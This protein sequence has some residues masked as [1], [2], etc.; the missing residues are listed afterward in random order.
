ML[1]FRRWPCTYKL[2]EQMIKINS[3]C[4]LDSQPR[5]QPHLAAAAHLPAAGGW[6]THPQLRR[7]ALPAW[8]LAALQTL[9]YCPAAPFVLL[10][11]PAIDHATQAGEELLACGGTAMQIALVQ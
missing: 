10:L 4:I 2:E 1:G 5:G 7:F 6:L 3:T 8:L 9:A 11:R